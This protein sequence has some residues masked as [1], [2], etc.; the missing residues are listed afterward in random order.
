MHL[1]NHQFLAKV[2]KSENEK[3]NGEPPVDYKTLF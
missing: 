1:T 2:Q 3:K